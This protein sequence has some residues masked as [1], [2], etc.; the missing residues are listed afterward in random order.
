M[1]KRYGL[2]G[3]LL[4]HLLFFSACAQ[5]PE[6]PTPLPDKAPH[7]LYVVPGA[8]EP[9]S[10]K[11]QFA[12]LFSEPMDVSTLTA[13]SILLSRGDPPMDQYK[14]TADL[15]KA[16]DKGDL[17]G[18]SLTF[19]V[20]E[21]GKVVIA[22]TDD[23]LDPNT[24][25][26]LI[27]TPRVM[28]R[29]HI[30]LKK[31]QDTDQDLLLLHYQTADQT[32]VPP[33]HTIFGDEVAHPLN[34]PAESASQPQVFPVSPT[35]TD[36]PPPPPDQSSLAARLVLNEIYYDAVGSDTD[37]FLFVELYGTPGFNISH[38]RIN[39]VNGS[40]GKVYD[41]ITFPEPA[42]VAPDGFYV[43]ADSQTGSTT[44]THVGRADLIDNFDPQNG[45]DAVQL[46]D[47]TGHLVDA[48]GYGEGVVP[49]AENGLVSYQGQL[50]PDVI[51]GHSLER[52]GA[53]LDTG[54]N[55]D[56]FTDRETPTPGR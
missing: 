30:P 49:I 21:E 45:P 24:V 19:S 6:K 46:L 12:I 28:S 33:V 34:P 20:R 39:F 10:T 40:D 23:E 55:H 54:N 43:I 26:S 7:L 56:D 31:S 38:Y 53:G 41:A 27:V 42:H 3:M 15:Y 17:S 9:L 2:E 50:A 48:V 29:D 37:G 5:V 47:T 13:E 44:L 52:R 14:S 16:I 25:Y 32:Y 11:P 8:D 1:K 51:N 18:A 22:S 4:L 35:T 36:I